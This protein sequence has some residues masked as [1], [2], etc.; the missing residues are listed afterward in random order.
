MTATS[1]KYDTTFFTLLINACLMVQLVKKNSNFPPLQMCI[2]QKALH[3]KKDLK[4]AV[5]SIGLDIVRWSD[6][7][8]IKINFNNVPPAAIVRVHLNV[9]ARFANFKYGEQAPKNNTGNPALH[10]VY[11]SAKVHSKI[12]QLYYTAKV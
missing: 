12:T 2:S 4:A 3:S 1:L 9:L 10:S 7:L 6:S 5:S 11:F 8:Q